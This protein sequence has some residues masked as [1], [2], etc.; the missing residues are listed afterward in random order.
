MGCDGLATA[1]G[2][3]ADPVSSVSTSTPENDED[4]DVGFPLNPTSYAI[5][6]GSF[7]GCVC[8]WTISACA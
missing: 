8:V 4:E 7:G 5:F 2:A 6:D 1:A 3:S